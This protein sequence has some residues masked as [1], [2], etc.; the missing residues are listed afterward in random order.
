M[1]KKTSKRERQK[2]FDEVYEKT[3]KW[4]GIVL[5]AALAVWLIFIAGRAVYY[6]LRLDGALKYSDGVVEA[7]ENDLYDN[8]G[9]AS[10]PRFY[11]YGEVGELEGWTRTVAGWR[12]VTNGVPEGS[13]FLY[14]PSDDPDSR[15]KIYICVA[16]GTYL[17]LAENIANGGSMVADDPSELVTGEI[18][19]HKTASVTYTYE[20]TLYDD[21][22][23]A[24]EE[25]ETIYDAL[26]Y[27]EAGDK[28]IMVNVY[29]TD[30]DAVNAVK[31]EA[32]KLVTVT[33]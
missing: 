2:K 16:N 14:T 3:L 19:G 22:G 30:E 21:D 10:S 7:A 8:V 15:T 17:E 6:G 1:A 33:R 13:D 20:N 18:D 5:A 26:T 12:G 23:N 27:I 28:S 4:I 31:D 25:T 11:K 32:P 9:S 29:S 24:L